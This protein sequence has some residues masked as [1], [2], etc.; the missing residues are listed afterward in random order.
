MK[1]Q[2]RIEK[3]LKTFVAYMIYQD[4]KPIVLDASEMQWADGV[5]AEGQP[6]MCDGYCLMEDAANALD[7]DIED[8]EEADKL[9]L[10]THMG[11]SS[12]E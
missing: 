10:E 7:I 8:R 1:D 11:H 9:L 4:R 3:L 12:Y 2:E 5:D 6:I